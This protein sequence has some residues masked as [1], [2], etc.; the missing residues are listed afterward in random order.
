VAAVSANVIIADDDEDVLSLLEEILVGVGY[1]V[2]AV[3]DGAA[4]LADFAARPYDVVITDMRMPYADGLAV[5]DGVRR[6]RPA[7]PVIVITGYSDYDDE[8]LRAR[9]AASCLRKPLQHLRDLPAA[10]ESVLSRA[11]S[12]DNRTLAKP[13]KRTGQGEPLQG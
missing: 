6:L 1:K 3:A 7:T 13:F 4:L 9:G 11:S 8:T 12:S 10:V 2:T 5:L